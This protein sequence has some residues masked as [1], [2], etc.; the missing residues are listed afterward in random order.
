MTSFMGFLM[1]LCIFTDIQFS[2]DY[3]IIHQIINECM[4][5]FNV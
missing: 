5:S 4:I 2:D 3:T 1:T